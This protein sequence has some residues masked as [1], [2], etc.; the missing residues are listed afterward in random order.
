VGIARNQIVTAMPYLILGIF[1]KS[2]LEI[3]RKIDEQLND[4]G[5]FVTPDLINLKCNFLLNIKI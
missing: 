5:M 4:I 2:A 3:L 1:F